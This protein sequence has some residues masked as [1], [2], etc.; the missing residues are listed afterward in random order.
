AAVDEPT[1]PIETTPVA[2]Q[3]GFTNWGSPWGPVKIWRTKD[4]TVYIRGLVNANPGPG[5]VLFNLPVGWRPTGGHLI[6]GSQEGDKH[7]RINIENNGNVVFVNSKNP[8]R[9]W[10]NVNLCFNADPNG[11]KDIP[12]MNRWVNYDANN[13]WQRARYKTT[14]LG[15]TFVE[16]LISGGTNGVVGQLPNGVGPG[17]RLIRLTDSTNETCR[18]DFIADGQIYIDMLGGN[19]G[20]TSITSCFLSKGRTDGWKVPGLQ[21]GFTN[22]GGEYSQVKYNLL[23]N[24][25]VF[26]EGLINTG[27]NVNYNRIFESSE[28]SPL[29]I[30]IMVAGIKGGTTKDGSH[31]NLEHY[32][33]GKISVLWPANN[34]HSMVHNYLKDTGT[35]AQQ[36]TY[37]IEYSFK[38]VGG[39][40]GAWMR[41]VSGH[42][43]NSYDYSLASHGNGHIKFRV[44]SSDG[45]ETGSSWVESS[46]VRVLK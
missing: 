5:K 36:I 3:N 18:L 20:H 38:P 2:F 37:Y 27:T 33:D 46:E 39:S 45:V 28:I 35:L 40:Y 25:E 29:N 17:G 30:N 19:S 32:P 15:V 43:T 26:I 11:W 42:G 9:S 14:G 23:E 8:A 41:I 10:L 22:Y 24:G 21:N 7:A 31:G 34:W 4:K 6:F 16:G 44:L 12:L 1:F 13:G